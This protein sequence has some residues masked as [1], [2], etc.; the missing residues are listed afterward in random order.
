MIAAAKRLPG[1]DAPN[2]EW[3]TGAAEDV[4]LSGTFSLA[5]AAESF[6][7][8]DWAVVCRRIPE[9][10]PSSALVLVEGR[11]EAASPW[12]DGLA[13][14]VARYS[15]NRDFEPYDVVDELTSRGCLMLNGRTRLGP[16]RFRQAVNDYITCIHS[17]NGFSRDRM[18]S[19]EVDR[20][21]A[22]VRDLVTPYAREGL[23]DLEISTRVAW[24]RARACA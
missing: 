11:F 6:H 16:H 15:T 12:A 10:V 9:V 4:T 17:R 2:I 21:D 24:G 13:S 14:L 23:L 8:F 7:W 22:A 3:L 20:F 1:G 18:S 5:L 19:A